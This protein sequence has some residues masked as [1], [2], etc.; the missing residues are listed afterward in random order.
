MVVHGPTNPRRRATRWEASSRWG[1]RSRRERPWSRSRTSAHGLR[2]ATDVHPD[3]ERL[4]QPAAARRRAPPPARLALLG[5][6]TRRRPPTARAIPRARL[7]AGS[8]HPEHRAAVSVPV[9]ILAR[10]EH[11]S[12]PICNASSSSRTPAMASPPPA[13]VAAG[14]AGARRS[15]PSRSPWPSSST[16]PGEKRFS[17]SQTCLRGAAHHRVRPTSTRRARPGDPSVA[18]APSE[19]VGAAAEGAETTCQSRDRCPETLVSQ[20]LKLP[21]HFTDLIRESRESFGADVAVFFGQ[22]SRVPR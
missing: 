18:T 22:V 14:A 9:S 11:W 15:M 20:R 8:L 1:R 2:A 7:T 4:G 16:T 19:P 10:E 21:R 3:V 5:S 13:L 12:S 6:C 17:R